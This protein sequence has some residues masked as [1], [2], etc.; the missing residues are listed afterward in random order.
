MSE[1]DFAGTFDEDY[2]YFYEAML[3]PER[4]AAEVEQI[5]E[6]LGPRDHVLDC[7]CGHGRIANA[8]AERGYGVTGIDQSELFLERARADAQA[9]DV[10]VEYVHGDMRE[11][12]WRE[13]FDGLVNWF[14]SF[15]YFDDETNRAVLRQFHGALRPGGRLVMETQNPVRLFRILLPSHHFERGEDLTVDIVRPDFET[16]RLRTDRIIVRDGKVRRTHFTV[17]IY[18][19]PELRDELIRA[20]FTN[21]RPGVEPNLDNRLLVVADRPPA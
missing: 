5:A 1:F 7:P 11:L 9:R 19:Y 6:L 4:T 8:L 13:R 2:L 15:G 16:W 3:T 21:V 14:T 17:R 20:G 12:P 18:S 10:D